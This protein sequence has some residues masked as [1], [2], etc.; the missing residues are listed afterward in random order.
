VGAQARVSEIIPN[1]SAALSKQV[2]VGD[3]I[4][5]AN[6]TTLEGLEHDRIVEVMLSSKG[7][8]VLELQSD[9]GYLEDDSFRKTVSESASCRSA[10]V[11]S[12]S[13]HPRASGRLAFV[14]NPCHY[15]GVTLTANCEQLVPPPTDHANVHVTFALV[16]PTCHVHGR[17]HAPTRPRT[18]A[19]AGDHPAET[20]RGAR[21]QDPL[22]ATAKRRRHRCPC[23]RSDCGSVCSNRLTCVSARMACMR[24][25]ARIDMRV[26]PNEHSCVLLK[27]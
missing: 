12:S 7:Q 8:T 20:Q 22:D 1:S 26:C 18:H 10:S 17:A 3:R 27:G 23:L 24:A 11:C 25:S 16:L 4:L 13:V 14:S 21:H 2:K 15:V 5:S 6:G 9:T 19:C